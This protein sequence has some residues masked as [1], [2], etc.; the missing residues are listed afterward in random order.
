MVWQDHGFSMIPSRFVNSEKSNA[1]L[2]LVYPATNGIYTWKY[3]RCTAT[4]LKTDAEQE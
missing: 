2:D 1:I 4:V 3:R